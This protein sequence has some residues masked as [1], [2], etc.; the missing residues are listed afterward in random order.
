[1]TTAI[2]WS[3]AANARRDSASARRHGRRFGLSRRRPTLHNAAGG[4]LLDEAEG[5]EVFD[6]LRIQDP[7]QVV[8]LVLHHASV[9]TG[10]G[11][12]DRRAAS[13]DAAITDPRV[14]WH[15]P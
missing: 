15:Q 13:V 7:V 11:A 12:V 6:A 10:H 4:E 2:A 9:K 8:A 5:A 3:R 14:A 1:M